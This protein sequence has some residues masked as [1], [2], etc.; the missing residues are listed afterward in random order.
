MAG[1]PVTAA[2]FTSQVSA[3]IAFQLGGPLCVQHLAGTQSIP[4][5]TWTPIA[6][7][8]TDVD[9]HGGAPVF[10]SS[11]YT[12]QVA[13]WY[14]YETQVD[15]APS[16]TAF[17][18]VAIQLNGNASQ[19]YAKVQVSGVTGVDTALCTATEVFMNPGDIIETIVFQLSGA[20]LNAQTTDGSPRAG[21]RWVHQ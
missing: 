8:T 6:W 5:N 14:S 4:N 7:D 17:R 20:A 11:L 10:V 1:A 12:C 15:F 9:T 21:L 2:Q 3:L 16:A 13:G 19:R 18:S